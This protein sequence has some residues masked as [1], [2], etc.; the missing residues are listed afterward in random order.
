[1]YT[2]RALASTVAL[3]DGLLG[4]RT[5]AIDQLASNTH[6]VTQIVVIVMA[7]VTGLS[8]LLSLLRTYQEAA[9]HPATR[10]GEPRG[11]A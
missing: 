8:L 5:F 9:A 1:M 3:S 4:A 2:R 7:S 11:G 10:M 6:F